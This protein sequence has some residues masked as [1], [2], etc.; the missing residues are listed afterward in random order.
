MKTLKF[1]P[2][3]IQSIIDG[4]RSTTW[5]LYDD[6]QIDVGDSVE[7]INSNNGQ[8]F[9]YAKVN[10]IVIKRIYDLNKSDEQNHDTY[11]NEQ[12][13]LDN[14]RKY[15]GPDVTVEDKVKIIKYTFYPDKIAEKV[16][17]NTTD[18]TDIKVFADG[19]SRGNPGPSASGYI[20]TDM[21]GNI[22]EKGGSYL[23]ITTNNQAEYQAVKLALTKAKS[24]NAK[25]VHVY[26]DSLLVANQINGV[27]KIKNR[28]LR[29]IHQSITELK[30]F[31]SKVSFTHIPRE[32]N[33]IADEQVNYI[34]D[35]QE[36][37]EIK[38]ELI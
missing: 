9:G 37:T 22:L 20:I 19:G 38:T 31:F 27:F 33:K 21:K 17:K 1:S 24:I 13:I 29:S 14:F 36:K 34:L 12:E 6:K 15:Y 28:E 32:L 2:Q 3:Q 18:T 30:S 35:T 10:E 16:A 4:N 11:K 7:F 25:N 5:R 8:T 26:L 23:G